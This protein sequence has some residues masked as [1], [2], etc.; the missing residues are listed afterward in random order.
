MCFLLLGYLCESMSQSGQKVSWVYHSSLLWLHSGYY[1]LQVSLAWPCS[2]GGTGLP[3]GFLNVSLLVW[4]FF[5][6]CLHSGGICLHALSLPPDVYHSCLLLCACQSI[7][8]RQ[9]PSLP[10][11]Y[12]IILFVPGLNYS[13]GFS[14]SLS[15]RRLKIPQYWW[16]FFPFPPQLH[17]SIP[18]PQSGK[19]SW[20]SYNFR[21][22]FRGPNGLDRGLSCPHLHCEGVFFW[23]PCLVEIHG[24]EPLSGYRFPYV[25]GS[26]G[27]YILVLAYT[28]AMN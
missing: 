25:F 19:G 7:G 11:L 2:W 21:L 9:G 3:E 27:P 1:W 26:Q 23:F 28:S 5:S 13:Q 14:P 15:G 20:L 18:V 6:L 22:L 4:S 10:S 16:D 12:S 8:E 24:E 17:G